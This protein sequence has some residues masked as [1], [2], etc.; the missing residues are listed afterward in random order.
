[1]FSVFQCDVYVWYTCNMPEHLDARTTISRDMFYLFILASKLPSQKKNKNLPPDHKMSE[2]RTLTNYIFLLGLMSCLHS[3]H[4]VAFH[5]AGS[6]HSRHCG[7]GLQRLQDYSTVHY[8]RYE[9]NRYA[10]SQIC[11]KQENFAKI[12]KHANLSQLDFLCPLWNCSI[13]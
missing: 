1:M 9:E 8:S 5:F 3:I 11:K 13:A 6:V 12:T 2:K 10:S 4:W 7:S